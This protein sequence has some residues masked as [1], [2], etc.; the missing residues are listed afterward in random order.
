VLRVCA[1]AAA[2]FGRAVDRDRTER[3]SN[4]I[5]RTLKVEGGGYRGSD[6]EAVLYADAN[7]TAA[8]ALLAAATVLDDSALARE[9]LASFERV[10]LAC[11]RPGAGLAHHASPDGAAVRGLLADHVAAIGALLDA[12][13]VSDGEP[14]R[15][16]AEEL[17]HIVV[18]DMWDGRSGGFFD[19]AVTPDDVGLLRRRHKLFVANAEAAIA[20]ARLSRLE[21]RKGFPDP[22]AFRKHAAGA[23]DAAARDLDGQGPLAAHYALASRHL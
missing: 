13:E 10:M 17:G 4:F 18:R 3:I 22:A 1:E 21:P 12:H 6:A 16:M 14:Y 7:A 20:F 5:T 2:L 15:M 8:S 23:L 19:R 11:Y 9:A